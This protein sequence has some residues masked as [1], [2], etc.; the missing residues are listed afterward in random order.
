[1]QAKEILRKVIKH[2]IPIEDIYRFSDKISSE[3][4]DVIDH[5]GSGFD[6]EEIE[7]IIQLCLITYTF[8]IGKV[9][10]PDTQYDKLMQ[11]Y[12]GRGHEPIVYPVCGPGSKVWEFKKHKVPFMVG[13]VSKCYDINQL[14]DV[15]KSNMHKVGDDAEVIVAPKYDGI[16]A[17]L[18]IHKGFV[19]KSALTRYDGIMGQDI[20]ALARLIN[21]DKIYPL[22]KSF[23]RDT[24]SD[25]VYI[26]IELLM[27]LSDFN[28]LKRIKDYANRRSAVSAIVNTPTN[29]EYGTYI[30][31]MPLLMAA[32]VDDG[33]KF[34]YVPEDSV[35]ISGKHIARR[36]V[37]EAKALLHKIRMPNYPYRI[38]GVVINA[39][40]EDKIWT[41][42]DGMSNGIAYK[43]NTNTG[44]TT[45][46]KA[47]WSIGRTGKATPM[48]N[49]E[50]CD[51]NE[52]VVTDVNVSNMTKFNRFDLR[53]GD[54][55]MI[56]SAGDVIPMLKEVVETTNGPRLTLSETCPFCGSHL[57]HK[58]TASNEESADLYCMNNKCDRLVIGK[59][60]NFFDKIGASGI[61]DATIGDIYNQYGIKSIPEFVTISLDKLEV[62]PGWGK[63]SATNY[64]N[65]IKRLRSVPL[66]YGEFLGALGIENIATRKCQKLC[67]VVPLNKLIKHAFKSE[68]KVFEDALEADG[69][70]VPS[71]KIFARFMYE[72]ADEIAKLSKLFETRPDREVIGNV[73][74]SG[75]II[76]HIKQEFELLGYETSNNVN[77]NTIAVITPNDSSNKINAARSKGIPIVRPK[78][79]EAFIAKLKHNMDLATYAQRDDYV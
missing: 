35:V 8:G 68:K 43:V 37:D 22:Y 64:V 29:L 51:V 2:D 4:Y 44:I 73:V 5:W 24:G 60:A 71:A 31:A 56:E 21:L 16:S 28:T 15:V 67:R 3:A 6:D 30:T 62:I 14:A 48:L 49:V 57:K 32:P 42:F 41:P 66:T 53:V 61:S 26:K 58:I 72:N 50:P 54:T 74:F 9:L 17:C 20:T 12:T 27:S 40:N 52:T 45:I 47:Y 69:F 33:Y 70:G 76:D 65:E 75:G 59:V 77:S 25:V 78:D 38:D 13:T 46:N 18:E 55:V 7:S 23:I 1:M 10:I 11:I 34:K 36:S 39:I 79:A 63:V 19:I